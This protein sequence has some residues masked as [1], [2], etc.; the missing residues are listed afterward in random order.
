MILI[1][2][3]EFGKEHWKTLSIVAFL[4]AIIIKLGYD[5]SQMSNLY[6]TS[7]ENSDK[8]IQEL[9]EIYSHELFLNEKALEEYKETM[10]QIEEEYRSSLEELKE[11][12]VETAQQHVDNFSGDK[13][14]L[15]R[16]IQAVFGFKYVP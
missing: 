10:R 7:Q 9:K 12:R 16:D 15:A 1:K 5:Y 2:I 4:L 11:I 8:Q 3:L 14:A 6:Q 13:E